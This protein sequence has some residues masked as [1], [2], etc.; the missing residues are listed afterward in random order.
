MQVKHGVDIVVSVSQ[1]MDLLKVSNIQSLANFFHEFLDYQKHLQQF[2]EAKNEHKDNLKPQMLAFVA[3]C[4][5]EFDMAN[6]T[7]IEAINWDWNPL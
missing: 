1:T 3:K 5:K 2:C 6:V 7:K 4:F